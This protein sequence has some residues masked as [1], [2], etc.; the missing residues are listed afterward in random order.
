VRPLREAKAADKVLK[1]R[2]EEVRSVF[3][4]DTTSLVVRG[5]SS[6]GLGPGPEQT[7]EWTTDY[8][9]KARRGFSMGG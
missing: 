8:V 9:I 1:E 3:K 6:H 7:P 4:T 2:S 5:A